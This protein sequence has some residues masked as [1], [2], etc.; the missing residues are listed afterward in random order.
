MKHPRCVGWGEMGL[1]YHYDNSPRDIQ[2]QV[3]IRQLK[4]AV[5]LKK[6]LTIHTREADS[7]TERILKEHVPKEHPASFHLFIYPSS[8]IIDRRLDSHSLLHRLPR[9]RST[10]PRPL[11]E[12][13]HRY[14]RGYHFC[15][16]PR[17][18]YTRPTF[19][20]ALYV[21]FNLNIFIPSTNSTRNRRAIHGSD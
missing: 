5:N 2:Q 17:Y 3:F 1:D 15:H 19:G 6:P 21:S 8:L 13:L 11:S 10:P 14:N 20:R 12:P 7:D 16:K 9:F 4:Q 18:L